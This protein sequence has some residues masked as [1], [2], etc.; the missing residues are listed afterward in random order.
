MSAEERKIVSQRMKNYWARR[1]SQKA[2]AQ[3]NSTS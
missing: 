1:R 2:S 3:T